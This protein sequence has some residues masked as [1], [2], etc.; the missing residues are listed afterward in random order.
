[1]AA[2]TENNTIGE[3]VEEEGKEDQR[4]EPADLLEEFWFFGNLFQRKNTDTLMKRW[5]S[6]PCPSSSDN[7]EMMSFTDYPPKEPPQVAG[8]PEVKPTESKKS[9]DS[10]RV[11]HRTPSL[12]PCLGKDEVVEEQQ[13][14]SRSH[15]RMSKSNISKVF[16]FLLPKK[17]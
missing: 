2:I 4:S 8:S 6:D 17:I 11:L 3:D 15:P 9:S 12:P 13:R 5:S 16:F 1:M 14:G 7:Q 10:C